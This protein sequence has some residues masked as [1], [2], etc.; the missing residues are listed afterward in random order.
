MRLRA[1]IYAGT[2]AEDRKK[3]PRE[4]GNGG[5]RNA[6][7]YAREEKEREGETKLTLYGG[8]GGLK[9]KKGQ[10]KRDPG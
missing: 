9:L 10:S 2:F 7:V 8:G 4:R 6:R 5:K 3:S 1:A